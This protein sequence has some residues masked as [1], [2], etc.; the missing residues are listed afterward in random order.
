[1]PSII[2]SMSIDHKEQVVIIGI[3]SGILY[4]IYY[5]LLEECRKPLQSIAKTNSEKHACTTC[6]LGYYWMNRR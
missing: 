1:M 3:K 4:L 5:M 2:V 6:T